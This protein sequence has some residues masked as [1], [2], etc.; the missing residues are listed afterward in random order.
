MTLKIIKT[1]SLIQ[2][3]GNL[4]INNF[5]KVEKKVNRF[6]KKK[7]KITL[8]I[9]NVNEIDTGAVDSIVKIFENALNSDKQ[10]DIV[11]NGTKDIYDELI[12]RDIL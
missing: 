10:I 6:L 9:D 12:A 3:N 5:K 11:G 8:N 4:N 2:L 1:D 7:S